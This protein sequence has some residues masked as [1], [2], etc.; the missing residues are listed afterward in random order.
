MVV[1][2]WSMHFANGRRPLKLSRPQPQMLEGRDALDSL[3]TPEVKKPLVRALKALDA[4]NLVES[5][6]HFADA[7]MIDPTNKAVLYF[8]ADAAQRAYFALKHQ[9]RSPPP[10]KLAQWRQCTM[11]LA[12]ACAEADPSDP[13][14][15]HN[16]GRF[17]QDDGDDE[18][19]IAWYKRALSLKR[20]QVE[21]WGNLGTAFYSLGLTLEAERAWTKCVS[22]EALNATGAIAQ[23][24][25]WLRRGDFQRG[26]P[27]LNNRWRDASFVAN[28]GRKDLPGQPWIG[29]PLRQRDRLLVHGEQ[30][31]GD[32][33][34]FARYICSL[35]E[36]GYPVAAIETRGP[37]QR[38]MQACFPEIPVV[39][40]EAPKDDWPHITHH[41]PMMSLPGILSI[42]EPPAPLAPDV[43]RFTYPHSEARRRAGICWR[44]TKGNLAD[45][46]RSIPVH[47]LN[48]LANIPG[49]QWVN[50]QYDPSGETDLQASLWLGNAEP[51]RYTD[52]LELADIM[53][54]L[55]MVVSCDTLALHVAG[56]LGVPT[57]AMHRYN[58]EWRWLQHTETTTLYPSVTNLTCPEPGDWTGLLQ[59]V[60]ERLSSY[61]DTVTRLDR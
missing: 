41:V 11:T 29:Q 10:E 21:S 28:Y 37:L 5:L 43:P 35:V 59:L 4:G 46:I 55:D 31:L 57:I 45:A 18:T 1:A 9:D 7:S 42:W 22:H 19:A 38:W 13:V 20:D 61:P 40:R 23:A 8:G 15:S 30:G 48:A 25:V 3:V 52:V 33:V 51:I 24:Y 32:H 12:M 27:A 17:V 56:S 60:R 26:W 50:L 36:Q 2:L 14:A 47:H 39:V 16:V 34:H 58:R 44:G 49:I 6:K 54:G 53:V